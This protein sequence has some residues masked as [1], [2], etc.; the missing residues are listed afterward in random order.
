[1][2]PPTIGKVTL[3]K[4]D[5]RRELKYLLATSATRVEIVDVPELHFVMLDG[6]IE[7]GETIAASPA[8]QAAFA[9]LYG[10]SFTLKFMSKRRR[11]HGFQEASQL[12]APRLA[13]G[14][15]AVHDGQIGSRPVEAR[16]QGAIGREAPPT[17]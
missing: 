4:L 1:M 5:L 16:E 2:T 6:R 7:P 15:E 10:L 14:G 11:A 9:A 12:G 13:E 17:L 8:F 3:Q